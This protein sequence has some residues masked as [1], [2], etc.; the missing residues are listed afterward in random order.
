MF[1]ERFYAS[2]TNSISGTISRCNTTPVRHSRFL[3]NFRTVFAL[4]MACRQR[5]KSDIESNNVRLC[6][7]RNVL[8]SSMFP[9]PT[10]QTLNQTLVRASFVLVC[11][12]SLVVCALPLP[13]IIKVINKLIS[14]S[15]LIYTMNYSKIF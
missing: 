13:E 6:A 4:K 14:V 11:T 9:P 8:R 2:R 10:L 5:L 7:H 15:Y 3:R 12:A 1:T